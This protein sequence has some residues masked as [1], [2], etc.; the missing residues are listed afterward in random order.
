MTDLEEL[1]EQCCEEWQKK[2][3]LLWLPP[4]ETPT[5]GSHIFLAQWC[6][7]VSTPSCPTSST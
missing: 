4:P 2:L 5:K 3:G 7:A 6:L 1:R